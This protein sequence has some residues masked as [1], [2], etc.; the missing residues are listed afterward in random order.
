VTPELERRPDGNGTALEKKQCKSDEN[1]TRQT[2]QAQASS[3]TR[4][5]IALAYIRRDWAPI[6]IRL[7]E[8][9]PR[10][11]NWPSLR[12]TE[13][14]APHYFD[15]EG[16][17]GVILGQ[18]SGGLVD[19]DLDCSEAIAL[20]RAH[21]PETGAI[22]GRASKPQ[23]H[24]LYPVNGPAPSRK[25]K[26]P[27]TSETLLELRGD[28]GLQTVFPGSTH[29]S[30]ERIEWA[31]HSEPLTIE[32]DV[33]SKR[34]KHLAARC[35]IKRYCP[36]VLGRPDLVAALS[37][38]DI[39][40]A[41]MLRELLDLPETSP[42]VNRIDRSNSVGQAGASL[43]H[44]L[45]DHVRDFTPRNIVGESLLAF[46]RNDLNDC[47][48]ELENQRE[49]GRA[50]LL[51]KKAIRM[52]V[53]IARGEISKSEVFDA[54]LQASNSNGL[55]GKNG[56]RDVRRQIDKG[57]R[58][59][60]EEAA[61]DSI[62]PLLPQAPAQATSIAATPFVA[63]TLASI[64]RREWLYDRH[65]IRKFVS[66]KIA[67]G[68]VGKSALTLAAAIS[69]AIGRD[70]FDG[71]KLMT[72]L[73]VWYWNGEDPRDEINRRI[74]AICLHYNLD[75]KDLEGWLFIDSGQDTPICLA[76]EDRSRVL[77]DVNG[78][79]SFEDTIE[80]NRI[81][82]VILDPF[83]AI[84]KISENNN[85]LIDQVLKLLGRIANHRNCSI[86]I[87][88]HIRKP[89]S[90]QNEATADDSRGGG[91]I[92]NAVRSCQVLNRMSKEEASQARI[93]PDDRYRYIRVDSGK[94]NLA[95]P[96]KAKW[97]YIASVQLPNGD[98]VQAV[99][100]WQ[101]PEAAQGLTTE[102]IEFV[103]SLAREGRYRWDSRATDWI[104]HPVATRLGLDFERLTRKTSRKFWVRVVKKG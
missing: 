64:P 94:Q 61:N 12:I 26:D 3:P 34:V 31:V 51:F 19:V 88:H 96:E 17:I 32:Y 44:S 93:E 80:R 29:P 52:G 33:L 16:N 47:V 48:W 55:V 8:K 4:V 22:F 10:N 87:V 58:I 103:Q 24:W 42:K 84:H 40:V 92:V 11:P 102:D 36:E 20:A 98:N 70:L 63:V 90:G 41:N 6:P 56:E 35:L 81:D 78:I 37:W 21:L 65:Y 60:A 100:Y 28:G 23:S 75:Q 5:E 50:D 83:I 79:R 45:P 89:S 72:Q 30:G 76:S 69:M 85:T 57:F 1:T 104:G 46:A 9:R 7:R 86:E 27:V 71:N 13:E 59:G 54:L 67:A 82:V 77:F 15:G 18:S 95:P 101:F 97:R 53:L 2:E 39:R 99:E 49:P 38:I 73:R 91:A 74:A 14:E 62:V 43:P 66:A 68:G 25:F